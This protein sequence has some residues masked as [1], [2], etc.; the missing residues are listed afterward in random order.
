MQKTQWVRFGMALV[1][2]ILVPGLAFAQATQVGQLSGD[3]KDA[4]GGVLPGASVTLTS[5]ERGASR[6]AITDAQG[7]FLFSAVPIGRY[8][9]SVSLQSF[10]ATT[11]ANNL[12]EAERTTN[13]SVVMTVAG[14]EVSTTVVGATP[15]VDAKNQTVE[16]RLRSDEFQKLAVGR[17]YQTLFGLAPGV[18]GDGNANVHGALRSNNVFMFDGVNTTDVTTGTFAANLNFEGIQEIV[19]RTGALG[20][21]YGRG[22]GGLVDVITKSGTNRLEGAFKFLMSNDDW[23]TQN[24]TANEV[25]G[26]SLARTKFD[27]VNKRYAATLGGPIQRNRAWFFGTYEYASL[28]SPAEQTNADTERGFANEEYIES[29]KSPWFIGRV[30]FQ[31]A[32]NHNMFVKYGTNPTT[33]FIN[34]YWTTSA[35]L[36]A[37][38]AQDQKGDDLSFQYSGVLGT[39]LTVTAMAARSTQRI[40]VVPYSTEG[41]ILG[42][43]PIIDLLDGRFYNGATFDGLVDRPRQQVSGAAEYF[44]RWGSND[45]FLKAGIDWQRM[46]ST[47]HFRFP[48]NRL[49]YMEGFNPQTRALC[50]GTATGPNCAT[51]LA[52]DEYED[53]PSVSKGN[54]FAFFFRDKFTVGSRMTVDGGIRIEKQ[55]GSSDVGAGTVDTTDISP[56]ASVSYDVTGDGR[57]LMVASAG[58]MFDGILQGFSDAFAAVPQQTN[59]QIFNFNTATNQYVFVTEDT[60]AESNFK[61]DLGISPRRMDE[62]TLGVQRQ[63][64]NV[65]GVG[66]RFIWRKWDNFID[67][68]MTFNPDGSDTR[69][70]QNVPE[71]RRNYR[72]VELT[73]DKRFSNNWAASGSYTWSRVRGNHVADDFTGLRDFEAATCGQQ[74]DPGLGTSTV[75]PANG[76]TWFLFPC[77]NVQPLLFGTPTFDRPHMVKFNGSYRRPVGAFDVTAGFVGMALSKPAFSKSRTVSV[78]I[79]GT[80]TQFQ[81]LTYFYEG[82]G[83]DRVDGMSFVGDLAIEGVYRAIRRSEMGVK[84]ETFNLFNTEERINIDTTAWCN[85]TTGSC[86]TTRANFGKATTRGSFVAPRAFRVTFLIR[87]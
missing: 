76:Q 11:L 52:F 5:V 38:T 75:N 3:V 79:P 30:T 27:S 56:R 2:L 64:S 8:N 4:T 51:Q 32:P 28:A 83:S 82:R 47:S 37:L 29:T 81:T 42:G 35:E 24:S 54:Q 19:I 1:A 87:Y 36:R 69:T 59:R 16:T 17:S 6:T 50:Q 86:A 68:V 48:T 15:I 10:K 44:T 65:F 33:G 46:E 43:A 74:V 63:L 25:T 22:T 71:G 41:A 67:D 13:I 31:P 66:A 21:E 7:R 20:V 70:V 49:Y 26:G 14:V 84:F 62:F 23:N 57:T 72:G 58:R 60:A 9:L 73:A 55:T 34:D 18:V 39:K 85:A 12:V 40:D 61:P 45:H 53:A 80:F 77:A 78:L